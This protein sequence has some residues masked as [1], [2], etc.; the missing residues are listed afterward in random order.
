MC[1]QESQEERLQ[2]LR[3]HIQS[4]RAKRLQVRQT[5]M[6]SFHT[7]HKSPSPQGEPGPRGAAS[8]PTS[9]SFPGSPACPEAQKPSCLPLEHKAAKEPQLRDLLRSYPKH[10]GTTAIGSIQIELQMLSTIRMP[11]TPGTGKDWA[12]TLSPGGMGTWHCGFQTPDTVHSSL[13]WH[14]HCAS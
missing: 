11:A 6:V 10:S 1:L 5:M 4:T 2:A 7:Q 12:Y 3:A 8:V 14:L 9:H 13:F